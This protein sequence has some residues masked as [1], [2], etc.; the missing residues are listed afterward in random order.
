MKQSTWRP[1]KHH[2]GR[3]SRIDRDMID[4]MIK[5]LEGHYNR[6]TWKWEELTEQFGLGCSAETTKR[7]MNAAGYHKCRACQKSWISSDQ[8][9]KRK[10]FCTE[11][12]NWPEW[13]LKLVCWS[14]ECHFHQ[15]S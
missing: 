6:R 15:N 11:M 10:V 2:S 8:A 14:D 9:E 3:K 12:L 1:G 13:K 4:K 5:A 7:H